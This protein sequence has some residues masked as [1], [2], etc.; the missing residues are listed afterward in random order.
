MHGSVCKP[1]GLAVSRPEERGRAKSQDLVADFS[2][3]MAF[4][5]QWR[6]LQVVCRAETKDRL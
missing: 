2:P 1:V 5:K 4:L 3:N 6:S